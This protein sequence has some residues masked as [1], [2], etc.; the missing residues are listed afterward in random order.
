MAHEDRIIVVTGAAGG[1]GRTVTQRWLEAGARVVAIDARQEALD[2]LGAH[3]RLATATA[4]LTTAEG[5]EA[6]VRFVRGAFGA[7][8][9]LLH[10]VGGFG[11]ARA[12]AEDAPATWERMMAIN[13]HAPFHTFRAM[14]PALRERGGGWIVG[15]SSRSAT[16]PSPQMSAYAASK[17]ALNAL[18]AAMALELRDE[19]IHVNLIL[20]STIDTPANRKSMGDAAAEKWVRPEDI[21]DATMYLCSPQAAAVYGATLEV[22][23]RA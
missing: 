7:P 17:A 4:D 23:G 19:G 13:A 22:Y 18:A 6:M 3:E 14:V 8:D 5:A 12:D 20:A 2:A 21:A 9:T 15:I 16:V 10:L 11:M 1:V